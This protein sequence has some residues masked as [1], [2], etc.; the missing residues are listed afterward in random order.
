MPRTPRGARVRL[1]DVAIEV[2][3]VVALGGVLLVGSV[4]AQAE[5][6]RQPQGSVP[7]TYGGAGDAF[8]D[9]G[10]ELGDGFRGFGRG[11]KDTFTGRRS[12][13]DYRKGKAIGTGFK[14]IGRGIA[15]GAWATGRAIKRAFR[16]G[17]EERD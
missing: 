5:R 11:L 13:D 7:N 2:A 4:P 16:G 3:A 10:H 1:Y 8:R 6:S 14:D 17:R 9:G 12:S 15:G